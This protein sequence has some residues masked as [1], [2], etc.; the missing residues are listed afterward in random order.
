MNSLKIGTITFIVFILACK[1]IVPEKSNQKEENSIVLIS[2]DFQEGDSLI[3]NLKFIKSIE[4]SCIRTE[5]V[6]EDN[7]EQREDFNSRCRFYKITHDYSVLKGVEEK[8]QFFKRNKI[9]YSLDLAN[10][11][12]DADDYKFVSLCSEKDGENIDSLIVYSYENYIEALVTKGAYFYV[13]NDRVFV[14]KFNEDEEG[15]HSDEWNEYRINKGKF[16]LIKRSL[17]N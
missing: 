4:D 15:I 14:Y 1:K 3:S 6:L 5:G 16:E 7:R 8:E 10:K 2:K 12:S 17:F 9:I 13:K 11:K